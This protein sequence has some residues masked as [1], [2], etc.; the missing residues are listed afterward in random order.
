MGQDMFAAFVLPVLFSIGG[1]LYGYFRFAERRPMLLL[2]LMLIFL[3]GAYVQ[4]SQPS[5]GLFSLLLL[6]GTFLFFLLVHH[7][8]SPA[9]KANPAG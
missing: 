4:Y 1:G 3:L 6:D 9:P 5:E 8:Q 2:N 7:L